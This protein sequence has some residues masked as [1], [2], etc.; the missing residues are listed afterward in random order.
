[1]SFNTSYTDTGLFG[2]YFITEPNANLYQACTSIIHEWMRLC[3]EENISEKEVSRAKNQLKTSLLLSLDGTTPIAE[4]IGRQMLIFNRRMSPL[5][6]DSLIEQ[7][8]KKKIAEVSR[9]YFLNKDLA[10][11]GYGQVGQLDKEAH[12]KLAQL[13][14]SKKKTLN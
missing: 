8:N 1:M 12:K 10:V 5:E 4:E 7:V 13:M 9:K 3:D 11:V 14:K 6:V 2:V